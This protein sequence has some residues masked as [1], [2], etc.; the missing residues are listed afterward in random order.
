[1]T[2]KLCAWCLFVR[3]VERPVEDRSAYCRECN[4]KYNYNEWKSNLG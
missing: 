4:K 1:V 2:V 3:G